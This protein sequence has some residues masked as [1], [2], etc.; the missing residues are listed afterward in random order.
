MSSVLPMHSASVQEVL[1]ATSELQPLAWT[2]GLGEVCRSLPLALSRAGC[3]VRVAV[4]GYRQVLE[5]TASW[6]V[7][8]EFRLP[9]VHGVARLREGL[10]ENSPVRVYVV[11]VPELFDREGGLYVRKDGPEWGDNVERFS[12]FSRA[13]VTLALDRIGLG[14]KP[15][16]LHC[17][18][19]QTGL[20]CFL[21]R[22]EPGRPATL[23]T[24]HNL[25]YA[26]IGDRRRFDALGLAAQF[27]TP[28]ALEFHGNFSLLKGGL[29]GADVITTVSPG[30]A[31]EIQG[32]ELGFGFDGLL[33]ERRD[34]LSGV[35]NG[36]D[37]GTWDPGVDPFIARRY[38]AATLSLKRENKAA[39]QRELGLNVDPDALLC[40]V[41]ARFA[42]QKGIDL[43]L[44]AVPELLNDPVQFAVL[45]EGDP[46]LQGWVRS[47]AWNHPEQVACAL[48]FIPE[49]SHRII[50]GA[51]V[52]VMPSRY[53]PCGLTQLYGLRYGTVPVVRHTGGLRDSVIGASAESLTHG[54]ATG[55]VFNDATSAAV[56]GALRYALALH[57][58]RSLWSRMQQAGMR[59]D[60]S[61]NASAVKYLD[62]Y[63]SAGARMES[64]EAAGAR[65]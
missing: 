31:Q 55:V 51:D 22:H 18:D 49:L 56:E 44:S 54:S 17:H 48:G 63:R 62:L 5:R 21:L 7:R 61:W 37:Y 11:D 29:V 30:Y 34:H 26:G 8:G 52:V 59:A 20:A 46:S 9:G 38:S 24:I 40:G 35:L 57:R 27:Y 47:L 58:D 64:R 10:L 2:G 36:V 23:F 28:E 19:W 12:W 65:G 13:V 4:P 45:G 50:A 53:E 43:L 3:E 16:V 39:L 42:Y 60:F 1:F 32:P 15:R 6:P 41:V 14:W 25:A 33:R